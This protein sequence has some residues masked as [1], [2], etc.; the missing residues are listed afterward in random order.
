MIEAVGLTIFRNI[1]VDEEELAVIH[2]GIGFG[3]VGL[4]FT[5]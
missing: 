3:D 1:G 2:R 4:A 5:Q